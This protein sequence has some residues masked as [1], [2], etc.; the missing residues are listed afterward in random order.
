MKQKVIFGLVGIAVVAYFAL[1]SFKHE[2][3]KGQSPL[4]DLTR[5]NFHAFEE[6][7]N[8]ASEE[9]RVVVLLSPT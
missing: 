8:N 9:T 5:A 3:P 1:G 4:T 2:T 6:Q 7:F